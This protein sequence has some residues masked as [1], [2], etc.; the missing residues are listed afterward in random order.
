[1]GLRER[2]QFAQCAHLLL[3]EFSSRA[4]RGVS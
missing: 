4:L 3:D 1:M 2:M